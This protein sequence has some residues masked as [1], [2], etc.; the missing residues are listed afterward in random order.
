MLLRN[1]MVWTNDGRFLPSGSVL[2][3]GDRIAGVGSDSAT[4]SR[5]SETAPRNID[6]RGQ[7]IMPGFVNFHTHLYSAFSRGLAIPGY[8]PSGFEDVLEGMWWKL[9]RELTT[10][11]I[12]MSAL[13]SG[14]EFLKNGVTTIFD[15]HS[16]P[17]SIAN[18]LN[19]ISKQLVERVGIRSS[20]CYEVSDRNGTREALRGIEENIRWLEKVRQ[21]DTQLLD[22]RLGLHASFTLSDQTLQ[23]FLDRIPGTVPGFHLHLAEGQADQDQT[24]RDHG[25]RIVERLD[26]L[27]IV[28][29]GTIAA[30]C[31]HLGEA[32]KDLLAER[33]VI[34]V[35]NPQSNMNNAVGVADVDGLLSRGIPVTLGNDGF[36]FNMLDDFKTS[37]LLHKLNQEDPSAMGPA[38]MADIFLGNNY[39]MASEIFDVELGRLE[40]GCKADLITVDY[41]SPT[42]VNKDNFVGH[43][44]FGLASSRFDVRDVVVNGDLVIEDGTH[45]KIDE[46][47]MYRQA[48]EQCRDFWKRLN[49]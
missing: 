49:D 20:L 32:E 33:G 41:N 43:L 28:Q 18:S 44:L 37:T 31:V 48:R 27:N 39:R 46:Q 8:S 6:C 9:D 13:V 4:L 14:L 22:G 17:D 23:E 21:D 15:H 2:I 30:H 29:P 19:V 7:V 35:H 10:D 24:I 5:Q 25:L 40:T 16:S 38:Q 42:P 3:E 1:G 26:R 34:A 47:E 45:T 11:D 12:R 36:G